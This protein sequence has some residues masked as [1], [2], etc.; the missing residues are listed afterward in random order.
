MG[1]DFREYSP[2]NTRIGFGFSK[3][4]DNFGGQ[5]RKELDDFTKSLGKQMNLVMM[6]ME[7]TKKI[8][9]KMRQKQMMEA[10]EKFRKK[11]LDKKVQNERIEKNKKWRDRKR[12]EYGDTELSDEGSIASRKCIE[13]MVR[14]ELKCCSCQQDMSPP[15]KIYQCGEGHS[16]CQQ[17]RYLEHGQI[18]QTCEGEI[19]GR[20]TMAE[21]ISAIVYSRTIILSSMTSI[22]TFQS[23]GYTERM[24]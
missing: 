20:N 2:D 15:L 6:R 23:D 16:V 7:E 14:S 4:D 11:E 1:A 9:M 21:N 10:E 3:G 5:R 12:S 22:N 17:C 24:L 19:I 18:C 13:W 8:R